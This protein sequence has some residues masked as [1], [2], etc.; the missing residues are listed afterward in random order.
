MNDFMIKMTRTVAICLVIAGQASAN[1]LHIKNDDT[2]QVNVEIEPGEGKTLTSSTTA[3][4]QVVKPGKEIVLELN[5]EILGDADT[6]S[7]KGSVKMP[8]LYN[9][10]GPLSVDKNYKIVFVG[11]K[12]GTVVCSSY[13]VLK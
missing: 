6:F 7:V 11:G 1:T 4:K 8:S 5:R 10:C 9:K 3:V 12:L 13:E 2:A